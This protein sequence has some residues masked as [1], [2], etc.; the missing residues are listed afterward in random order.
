MSRKKYHTILT[1][2]LASDNPS[3]R[4]LIDHLENQ[5]TSYYRSKELVRLAEVGLQADGPVTAG[6]DFEP[7]RRRRAAR[8]NSTPAAP[9]PP[10]PPPHPPKPVVDP[11]LDDLVGAMGG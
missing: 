1:V 5:I 6:D 11:E 10:P 4:A 7:R 9:P 3:H 8:R 2:R